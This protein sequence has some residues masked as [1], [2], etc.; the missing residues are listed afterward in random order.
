M[1]DYGQ[2]M[3]ILSTGVIEKHKFKHDEYLNGVWSKVFSINSNFI[4]F[5]KIERVISTDHDSKVRGETFK[6][7]QKDWRFGIWHDWH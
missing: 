4:E 7:L 1:G 6:E 2:T 3:P 5:T